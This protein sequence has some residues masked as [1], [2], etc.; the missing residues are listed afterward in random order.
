MAS[1]LRF[2]CPVRHQTFLKG[3][4]TLGAVFKLILGRFRA[5]Q[6][7]KRRSKARWILTFKHF[8]VKTHKPAWLWASSKSTKRRDMVFNAETVSAF[9]Y[10]ITAKPFRRFLKVFGHLLLLCLPRRC[11]ILNLWQLV[12][13]YHVALLT[14]CHSVTKGLFA[15]PF[16]TS[17]GRFGKMNSSKNCFSSCVVHRTILTL[18]RC[19]CFS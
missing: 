1:K 2:S 10:L 18:P 14:F 19:C 17:F 15:Y 4:I 6:G 5:F 3:G 13:A 8:H 7:F 12:S 16:S 9:F 11:S